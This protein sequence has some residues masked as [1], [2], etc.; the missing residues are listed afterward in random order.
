MTMIHVLKTWTEYF[1][2]VAADE[3]TFEV[4]KD[5]RNY[6]VG[7]TLI[8]KEWDNLRKSHTGSQTCVEVTYILKDPQFVKDGY[9]IM[10]IKPS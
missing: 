7:D 5:D 2:A 8:L 9:V 6:Q 3:K 10:G 4:R 1:N